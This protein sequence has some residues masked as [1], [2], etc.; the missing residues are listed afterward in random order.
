MNRSLPS[1][2]GA[3]LVA[4]LFAGGAAAIGSSFGGGAG[5]VAA[6][7]ACLLTGGGD[8]TVNGD[9]AKGVILDP[10]AGT[11]AELEAAGINK[12]SASTET[13]A[14]TNSGA[15]VMNVSV[16]GQCSAATAAFGA[17]TLTGTLTHSG[18]SPDAT[19][20]GN[21]DWRVTSAGTGSV[22]LEPGDDVIDLVRDNAIVGEIALAAAGPT[23][24]V[25]TA[26]NQATFAPR[27]AA[28][29]GFIVSNNSDIAATVAV[30]SV[31]D[32]AAGGL[33][34]VQGSGH[35]KS[36]GTAPT[37]IDTGSCS[38]ETLVGTVTDTRGTIESDCTAGQTTIITF[39]NAYG[40]AP[41]CV[42]SPANAAA[43]ATSTVTPET[44]YCVA[45]TTALTITANDAGWT[46]G[47]VTYIC[48]E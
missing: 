5:G 45:S 26:A 34:A 9:D 48:M 39:A 24:R 13:F 29:G 30:M 15:G 31:G 17:T 44:T 37:T 6:S 21:E 22:Q 27:S 14:F 43:A 46:N 11:S 47:H 41:F 23:F 40:A 3:L 1:F 18:A 35:L 19:T 38:G 25:S 4:G 36:T 28:S 32:S 2:I 42:C 8:C 33:F 10:S 16:D 7:L 20:A 12:N